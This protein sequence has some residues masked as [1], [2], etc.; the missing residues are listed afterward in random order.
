MDALRLSEARW[1]TIVNSAVDG[2]IVIDARGRIVVSWDEVA[3]G[4]RMA[5]LRELRRDADR[6][7][8][9][10]AVTLAAQ[11]PAVYPVVASTA[12]GLVAVWTAGSGESATIAVRTLEKGTVPIS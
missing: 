12:S 1:R 9:G 2:I 10:D 7:S 6:V 8:F 3:G 11:G 5:V 4:T